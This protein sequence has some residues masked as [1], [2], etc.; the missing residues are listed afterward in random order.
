MEAATLL[1]DAYSRTPMSHYLRRPGIFMTD[2]MHFPTLRHLV[3]RKAARRENWNMLPRDIFNTGFG[4]LL[5]E[6]SP[7]SQEKIFWCLTVV[8]NAIALWNA[9]AMEQVVAQAA[10]DGLEITDEYLKH[11][12]PTMTEHINFVGRFFLDFN[13]KPPFQLAVSYYMTNLLQA[14]LKPEKHGFLQ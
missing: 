3:M 8:Q 5:R 1:A 14:K 9:L 12:F 10:K 4:G 13:R 11:I 7:E 6:K 2:A